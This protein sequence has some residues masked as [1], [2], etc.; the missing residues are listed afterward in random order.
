MN[1]RSRSP[2]EV[3]EFQTYFSRDPIEGVDFQE[4]YFKDVDFYEYF[5]GG[6]TEG[7]DF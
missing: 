5:F 1:I 4:N 6:Q 3:V 7:K 2:F